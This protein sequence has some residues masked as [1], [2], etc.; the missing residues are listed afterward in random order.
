MMEHFLETLPIDMRV[1]LVD[2]KPKTIDDM[3]RLSD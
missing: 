3:A 1:W 2:Q